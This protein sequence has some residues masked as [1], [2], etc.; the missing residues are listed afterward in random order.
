MRV[1]VVE[2]VTDVAADAGRRQVQ[3][4]DGE[5][6]EQEIVEVARSVVVAEDVVL[7]R[8]GHGRRRHRAECSHRQFCTPFNTDAAQSSTLILQHGLMLA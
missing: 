7:G 1:D 6:L 2:L 3:D 4:A 5:R 8:R